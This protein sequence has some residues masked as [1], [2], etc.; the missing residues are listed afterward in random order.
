M[1][2]INLK[3]YAK[4]LPIIF[5]VFITLW[6]RLINLGY[7][8]YQGDEIKALY[9]PDTGQSLTDY[10]FL[11]RKGPTQFITSYLIYLFHPTYTN[12]FL[13]RLPFALVGILAIF[14]FYQFVKLQY[15]RRI[16]IYASL[17]LTINGLFIGLMRIVQYQPF[18]ILFSVLALYAFSLALKFE[19]WKITGIYL[20]IFSWALALLTHYDGIFIAPFVAYLLYRWNSKFTDIPNRTKFKH[21]ILSGL[22]GALL[23]A[24]FYVPFILSVSESTLEYWTNRTS[25]V[26][27]WTTPSSIFTFRLYNPLFVIYIY[28]FLGLFSLVKIK[29]TYPLV[30][31]FLFPWIILEVFIVDPGTHIYTYIMPA[32]IIVAFGVLVIEE[33][34]IK[35]LGDRYGNI[36]SAAALTVVFVLLFSLAHFIFVDHTPEYPWEDRRLLFWT[37]KKPSIEYRI[38]AF[39]FPYYRHWEAIGDLVTSTENNGYY[40]TNENKSIASHYAPYI[41]NIRNSGYYIHIYNPQSFRDKLADDKIRYW[42]KRYQ[43]VKVFENQGG[44]VAE[45]YYMPEGNVREIKEAGY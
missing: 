5:L 39:G 3:A 21:L 25:G 14:F 15:G 11:Q 8:D 26:F 6:L 20:G 45:I 32:S 19:R 35:I 2:K 16:A 22:G 12:Q 24:S 44:V 4:L 30:L 27:L 7:S 42:R 17:F 38:W 23:L 31:W 41:F 13:T 37:I 10:L 1:A 36:L 33:L 18:V 9:L 40:S 29:Q 34:I 43:P 28:A